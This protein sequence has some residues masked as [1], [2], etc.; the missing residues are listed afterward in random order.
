MNLLTNAQCPADLLFSTYQYIQSYI[1]HDLYKY[2][3]SYGSKV[4]KQIVT[5]N[6]PPKN[7]FCMILMKYCSINKR[8]RN[9]TTQ[10]L[11]GYRTDFL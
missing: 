3:N 7:L 10:I 2:E 9:E 5:K 8:H 1:L 6:P 11:V 4:T